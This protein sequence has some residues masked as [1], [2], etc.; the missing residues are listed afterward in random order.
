M[1]CPNFPHLPHPFFNTSSICNSA[2]ATVYSNYEWCELT[3]QR[4]TRNEDS[5]CPS[6]GFNHAHGAARRG[7]R[8]RWFQ[9]A[10]I[11]LFL[12]FAAQWQVAAAAGPLLGKPPQLTRCRWFP[13]SLGIL[14]IL[15]RKAGDGGTQVTSRRHTVPQR[16]VGL[17][18]GESNSNETICIK[19]NMIVQ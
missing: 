16:V 2:C 19:G 14:G 10:L 15:S 6:I 5:N 3:E 4:L 18:P 7:A 8:C 17:R 13:R 1:K 12:F 9:C 11:E